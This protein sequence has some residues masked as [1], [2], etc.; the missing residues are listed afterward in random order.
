[1][2]NIETNSSYVH[3]QICIKQNKESNDFRCLNIR[4]KK[5]IYVLLAGLTI[6]TIILS[7]TIPLVLNARK[8]KDTSNLTDVE[9]STTKSPEM[10]AGI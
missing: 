4:R 3:R 1:M 8:A 7:V 10:V 9:A 5:L 2:S 6:V